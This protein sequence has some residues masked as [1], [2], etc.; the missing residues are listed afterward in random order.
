MGIDFTVFKG[1]KSGEI[2][3][4][5]GHRDVGPTQALVELS[6][7][8]VCGTDEHYKHADQGLGHEGVGIIKEVGS[9]VELIS[10]LRVGDRVGMGVSTLT[11]LRGPCAPTSGQ[12]FKCQNSEQFGTAN[13]DQGCFGSGVAWD[14]TALFKI[15]DEIS[16][17][18][19]GPLMCGGATV[20][21]PLY[22]HGFK[23]GDRIGIIGIGGLGHLAIQMASKMGMEAVVFSGTQ[24]KKEEAFQ[25][26][27]SE[28]YATKGVTKLQGVQLVDGLLITTSVLPD[29]ALYL[30]ILA[31]FAKIFPLT[32]S[33]DKIPV[34]ALPFVLY[35][36]S[37]IGSGG[38]HPQSIKA[39][40]RFCAKHDIKPVIEKFPMTKQGV[41]EAMKKL[42]EGK[43]RYRG[44]LV[45]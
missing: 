6:H 36:Y 29:L 10:D 30:P 18:S 37:I 20:W 35:G 23:A 12:H 43:V 39:M 38:A 24:S 4:S 42:E 2:L 40:L 7:C 19:A 16:S 21:G 28:F 32:I 34:P 14:V 41:N 31:P 33:M 22:E 13:L 44:V 27:A 9:L 5:K 26:G 45:V 1:S 17:E 8:G 11:L 25:L 15:P 3:E